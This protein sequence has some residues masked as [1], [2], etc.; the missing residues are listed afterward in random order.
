MSHVPGH[1]PPTDRLVCALDKYINGN[2]YLYHRIL[3][4]FSGI[5]D[6]CIKFF[7]NEWEHIR[8]DPE[9]WRQFDKWDVE[10]SHGLRL[11]PSYRRCRKCVETGFVVKIDCDYVWTPVTRT[12]RDD[13]SP[14]ES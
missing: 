13:G 3:G 4:Y 5:P 2:R 14:L 8:S 12:K 6:C 7:V 9:R 1:K 11:R 10:K